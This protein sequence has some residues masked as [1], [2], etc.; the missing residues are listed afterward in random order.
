MIG[1]LTEGNITRALI[2]FSIPMILGNLLQQLYNVAD[3]FIV[4]HYI[5]TDALAA[6]GS[7]FT[8]MTFL[9]SIILGLCMGSGILFSM[10]YG[11]K[12]LDKMKTSFFVS[13]VGIGIFSIGLEIVCLLA[14]DLILN[15]MN[16]PRDIFTDTHQYLFIIFLGLVFTFIYNYFSSLLRALGN[17]KIPL[18]FLAL[19]SIINIGLDIYLVAE[20]AMGVAGAAVATLIAQAF[21]AIG[22]MLYVFLSQKELL[23]QRKHWHFEREIFEKIK[24]YSLLTCIQQ[25]VMNFGIL[26]IQGLVNSFGL[27]TMSAFAAAVKIDSFAYMPV[28]DFGNAFSTYI[29]QNK[30]AGLE[31]R[32]HKG[33]KVAV[34]MAS[35]FCI[36]ISALVFIF[37]DKLMLIF[38]ESSKSEIIYQGAQYLRIEG[39]CY[40]GIGCLFLLYGYY[41]GVGKP[42]ISVFLT[43]ISLGTRVVLA[44]LLAPL[45]GTLAIWWAIPIGWFLADLIGI[46][47][48]LKKER[49][50]NR[51]IDK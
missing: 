32:I 24:A 27:V 28:Q 48:G 15:F 34:V 33:F 39:A 23:P 18:I 19:A 20:V 42:G 37:A 45:F 41:R 47:Y 51:Y 40:L 30:G 35:I 31:E 16:I 50:T 22:I 14:I 44:Y 11:A 2:K 38:I 9:T 10:F 1:K 17:S 36:F 3:T 26:M 21:S 46:M 12:Q 13:F 8:I 49:W 7:S 6:V 29:A 25:S 43:V 5:G 4:G